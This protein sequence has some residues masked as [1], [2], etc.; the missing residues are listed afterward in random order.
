MLLEYYD[1]FLAHDALVRTNRRAVA[2]LFVRLSAR[3][4][5]TGVHCDHTDDTVHFSADSSLQL[6]SPMFWA[7][8]HQSMSTY[9]KWFF[10]FYLE[11]GWGMDVQ[12]RPS[13]KRY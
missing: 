12:T 5:W 13:I 6:D 9:C 3:P 8:R 7:P 10:Q 4:V 2:M 11:E 1:Q